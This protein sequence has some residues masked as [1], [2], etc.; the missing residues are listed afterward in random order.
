MHTSYKRPKT[1]SGVVRKRKKKNNKKSNNTKNSTLSAYHSSNRKV[2]SSSSTS[3]IKSQINHRQKQAGKWRRRKRPFSAKHN[4]KDIY[5]NVK[6]NDDLQNISYLEN[7]LETSTLDMNEDIYNS[8]NNNNNNNKYNSNYYNTVEDDMT[9]MSK[10]LSNNNYNNNINFLS[11]EDIENNAMDM[12]YFTNTTTSKPYVCDICKRGFDSKYSM[13]CHRQKLHEHISEPLSPESPDP[14]HYKHNGK[15]D[16]G[17][18]NMIP[19]VYSS[20]GT[21]QLLNR[22]KKTPKV[23]NTSWY[24][25]KNHKNSNITFEEDIIEEN[26]YIGIKNK[27]LSVSYDNIV[28][29][30]KKNK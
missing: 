8:N 29:S 13:V 18:N 14:Y 28:W 21:R 9:S 2:S 16:N 7:S 19:F 20:R 23:F 6:R 3:I 5:N 30:R 15:D 1:S 17:F 11:D 4:I 25:N 27:K 22:N 10:T 24:V 26:K 12:S